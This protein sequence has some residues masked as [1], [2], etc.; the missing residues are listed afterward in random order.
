MIQFKSN[1]FLIIAGIIFSVFTFKAQESVKPE[2][3]KKMYMGFGFDASVTN[4]GHGSFYGAHLSFGKGR[5][6]IKLGP[7]LHRRSSELTGGR[8]SYSYILAGMDGE[9]Q[10]GM[11]FPESNNGSCHISLYTYLQYINNTK[12]SFQ[13]AKEETVLYTDSVIRDWNEARIST[14]EGAIGAEIDVKLFHYL[15][16]RTFVGIGIYSYLN[17]IPGMYQEQTGLMFLMGTGFDIPTFKK[18]KKK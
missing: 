9:E 17:H 6:S 12:L 2:P 3:K 4:N 7:V 8:L 1:T 13:R 16:W 18:R 5:S 15:Q 14:I 10:L 11:G